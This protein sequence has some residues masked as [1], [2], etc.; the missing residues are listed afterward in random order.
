MF[1]YFL[2]GGMLCLF[3][4]AA[5]SLATPPHLDVTLHDISPNLICNL[6]SAKILDDSVSRV[7]LVVEGV[8]EPTPVEV[9][10][11][12][13]SSASMNDTDPN[14]KRI[15]A[16]KNFVGVL[17]P[18]RDNVGLVIWNLGVEA[19]VPLTNNFQMINKS[20]ED[21]NSKGSTDIYF[22]LKEAID[23]L[24]NGSD[25]AQKYVILLSDGTSDVSEPHDFSRELV[26]ANNAGIE[27]W[28][29]GFSVG[30]EG[31]NT[32]KEIA[33]FTG[34]EYRPANEVT[35]GRVLPDIYRKPSKLAGKNASVKYLAPADLLYSI[36]Y[37]H[38]EGTNKVFIWNLGDLYVG[39]KW[40]KTFRVSSENAGV[41]TLGKS[42]GSAVSYVTQNGTLEDIFIDSRILVVMDS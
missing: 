18:S 8:G 7:T 15:E 38:I 2:M 26:R 40:I 19:S 37:D 14:N 17:D 20:M 5:G 16:A 23:M 25:E 34:G 1:R 11:S 6:S 10:L 32:L 24:I 29:V 36:D 4:L 41:F 3:T 30:S 28:T 39:D 22:G 42:P 27:I 9:V 33:H 13:D 21:T 31:E 35:I 12:I